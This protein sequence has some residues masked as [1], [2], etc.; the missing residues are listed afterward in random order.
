MNDN[1]SPP[2]TLEENLV[3]A[4]LLI[5]TVM[6]QGEAER[7]AYQSGFIDGGDAMLPY[8]INAF[9][10]GYAQAEADM[11]ALWAE[12]ARKVRELGLPHV[13][14]HSD[15]RNEELEAAKPKPGDFAGVM[16][17]P[18]AL[19]PYMAAVDSIGKRPERRAA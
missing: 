15:I 18:H 12:T 11:D 19:D 2:K 10:L 16:N 3:A 14:S 17:D 9:E 5:R 6:A 8:V 7:N 1:V 4:D 13:T